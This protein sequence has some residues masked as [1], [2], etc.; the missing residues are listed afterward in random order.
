MNKEYLNECFSYCRNTGALTWAARPLDHFKTERGWKTFLSQR[1][2]KML[3]VL[4][5][6]G[7]GGYTL[8]LGLMKNFT[9]VIG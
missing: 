6:P 1:A 3:G 4:V 2:G 5:T 8:R 9:Y 7:M